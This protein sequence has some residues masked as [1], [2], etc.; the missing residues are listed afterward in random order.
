M[1]KS[2]MFLQVETEVGIPTIY[3]ERFFAAFVSGESLACIY[4]GRHYLK[5]R[6]TPESEF[7]LYSSGEG[8]DD[9]VQW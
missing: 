4:Q 3:N 7:E 8:D 6:E 1:T 9:W 2:E 5:I